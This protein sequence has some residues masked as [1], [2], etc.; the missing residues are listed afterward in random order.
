MKCKEKQRRHSRS[1]FWLFSLCHKNL[2]NRHF[3]TRIFAI[4]LCV[5]TKAMEVFKRNMYGWEKC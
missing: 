4:R 5:P 1:N 3:D 2:N